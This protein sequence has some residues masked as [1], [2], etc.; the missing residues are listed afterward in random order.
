M[1]RRAPRS[2]ERRDLPLPYAPSG[3]P[4]EVIKMLNADFVEVAKSKPFVDFCERS[5]MIPVSGTPADV[6]AQLL[7]EISDWER[8]AKLANFAPEY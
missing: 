8:M 7:A 5:G 6:A 4:D 2:S 3:T 1:V